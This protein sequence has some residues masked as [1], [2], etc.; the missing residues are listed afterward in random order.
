MGSTF[1]LELIT[2]FYDSC[3]ARYSKYCNDANVY[4]FI[5]RERVDEGKAFGGKC[6]G[7]KTTGLDEAK[8]SARPGN[9]MCNAVHVVR[10]IPLDIA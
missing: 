3:S 10:D 5:S 6:S 7:E 8:Y 4:Y 2:L 1:S 9:H